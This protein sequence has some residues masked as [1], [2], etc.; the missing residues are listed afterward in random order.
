MHIFLAKNDQWSTHLHHEVQEQFLV[1]ANLIKNLGIVEVKDEVILKGQQVA[2]ALATLPFCQII[3]QDS[4]N[5]QARACTEQ[6]QNIVD[7]K[8][9]KLHVFSLTQKYG[10]TTSGRAEL[11]KDQ[12][13]KTL[14]KQSIVAHIGGVNSELPLVQVM[15][16][17][18][19]S[20]R[21]SVLKSQ[22]VE[23]F[24][25]LLGPFIGG[26]TTIKDDL[27]APSRAFKK[28]I[29]A[30]KILGSFIT[31]QDRVL[32]LGASPGGWSYVALE[33]GAQVT[34]VDRSVLDS[35]VM[36]RPELEFIKADAFR[37][38][39]DENYDWVISD[40]ISAPERVIELIEKWPIQRAIPHFIFTIKF[41][42][43][44]NYQ[45]LKLIKNSLRSYQGQVIF[46]QLN[47]NKNEVMVM[48][49]RSQ[50]T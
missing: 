39:T 42:G 48:G 37:F 46:R 15:I 40:I 41:K 10:V 25:S 27:K 21:V 22:D 47:V 1:P 26:H 30:Q 45:V 20:L 18:D 12:L 19:R 33:K 23:H 44:E 43:E 35:K 13:K 6:I 11:L 38:E 7:K 34:A 4:I 2:F 24:Q 14:K 29:E 32:D 8:H 9:L 3:P 5:N 49:K 50:S 28:L 36:E 16:W 17:P 31:N